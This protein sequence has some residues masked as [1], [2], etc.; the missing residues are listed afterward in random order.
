MRFFIRS[1]SPNRASSRGTGLQLPKTCR[2]T[3][4]RKQSLHVHRR[5]ARVIAFSTRPEN[6]DLV[7]SLRHLEDLTNPALKGKLGICHP[8]FGTASGHFAA[9]Y[10]LWG[11]PKFIDVMKKLRD[12]EIKLLGGNSVVADEV[13]PAIWSSDPR[14]TTTWP[15]A[16]KTNNPSMASF[17]TREPMIRARCSSPAQSQ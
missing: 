8:G 10:V 2:P 12:N 7:G 4:R 17:P 1:I 9:M 3:A 16:K 5:P 6:K 13:V 14:T 15:K 11:E